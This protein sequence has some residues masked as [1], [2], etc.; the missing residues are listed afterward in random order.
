MEADSNATF[1]TADGIA[2]G[3]VDYMSPEQALGSEVDGRS[4]VFS[5]GCAMFHLMTGKLAFP[6]ESPIDRLGRRLNS[7]PVPISDHIPEIPSAAVRVLDKMMALKPQDRFPSA[8]G[9]GRGHA[10]RAPAAVSLRRLRRPFAGPSA[11]PPLALKDAPSGGAQRG[12]P[13]PTEHRRGRPQPVV[14]RS[15]SG[16]SGDGSRPWLGRSSGGRSASLLGLDRDRSSRSSG[17]GVAAG[18]FLR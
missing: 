14:E 2:V 18:Y 6:G 17:P 12:V 8:A 10:E 7:K 15:R 16:P 5:L 11:S 13:R 1:A 4:D 9:G 3:T